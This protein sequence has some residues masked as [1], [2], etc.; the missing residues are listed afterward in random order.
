MFLSNGSFRVA[1]QGLSGNILLGANNLGIQ[2]KIYLGGGLSLSNDTLVSSGGGGSSALFPN[3]VKVIEDTAYLLSSADAGYY[4]VAINPNT[5]FIMPTPCPFSVGDVIGLAGDLDTTT[6]DVSSTVT[7]IQIF[8]GQLPENGETF[9]MQCVDVGAGA[10]MLPLTAIIDD[11]GTFKTLNK[12]LYDKTVTPPAYDD[13][14]AAGAAGLTTGM[15]YMT[16]GS[17]SAPLNAAGILMIK[18]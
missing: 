7:D 8:T 14:A 11:N 10:E 17:G 5:H 12:Y 15:V 13:D 3:G 9:I 4:L 2:K 6:F 1:N 16:T 18:Q